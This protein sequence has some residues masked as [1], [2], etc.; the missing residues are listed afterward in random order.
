MVAPDFLA[1]LRHISDTQAADAAFVGLEVAWSPGRWQ[2]TQPEC[3]YS[4]AGRVG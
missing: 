1:L 4:Y 2:F 3:P